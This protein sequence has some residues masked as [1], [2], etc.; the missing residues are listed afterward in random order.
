MEKLGEVIVIL[1][2]ACVLL[3]W[4]CY[5]LVDWLFIDDAIKCS[6]PITPEIQLVVKRTL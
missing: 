1:C 5:E 2:V 6:K 3:F 4:G